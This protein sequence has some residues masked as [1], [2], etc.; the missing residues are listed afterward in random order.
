MQ[1]AVELRAA[2]RERERERQKLQLQNRIST[3]KR[4]NGDFAALFKRHFK[5][6]ITSAKMEKTLL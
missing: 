4:E 2:A 1:G 3:P 6:R 5:R